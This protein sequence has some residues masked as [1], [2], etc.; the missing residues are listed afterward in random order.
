[1][2]RILMKGPGFATLCS[3][4]VLGCCMHVCTGVFFRESRC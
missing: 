4:S 2:A 1:V 3:G